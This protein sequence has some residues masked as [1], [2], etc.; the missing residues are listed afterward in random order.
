MAMPSNAQA[1]VYG[2]VPTEGVMRL[3]VLV[4]LAI[5]GSL[6]IALAGQIKVPFYP[7][8]ATLQTLACL[9]IGAAFGLR[10]GVATVAFYLAQ[11]AL[12]LPVFTGGA[13]LAYMAGPTGGFLIGFMACA[14]AAGWAA[15]RGW[16]ARPMLMFAAMLVGSIVMMTL[17]FAWLSTLIGADKAWIAGVQPF[18][19]SELTKAVLA[20]GV[21][22]VAVGWLRRR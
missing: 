22:A 8:P 15:D 13:G 5:G 1:P 7:V 17:G 6:L 10:L 2:A 20:S 3:V 4:L 16:N 14:A 12:G 19:L 21:M 9:L 18:L 11:G